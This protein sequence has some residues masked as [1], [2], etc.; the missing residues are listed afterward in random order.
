MDKKNQK[1][2]LWAIGIAIFLLVISQLPIVPWFA[3][4]TRTTCAEK[5]LSYFDMDGNVLDAQGIN[6]GNAYNVSFES[7]K[8]GQAVRF[9]GTTTSYVDF[10]LISSEN[11]TIIMWIKNYS[12]GSDWYFAS[13]TNGVSGSNE[14]IPLNSQFG[15]GLNVSVDE[16][17]VFSP[18]LTSEE[19]SNFSVGRKVCYTVS[20]EE[21]ISCQDF[22]T[23]Q[24][25]DPGYGCLNYSG[26]FFPN[27]EY[28]WLESS[29][30]KIENNLCGR[31]F[32]C[33]TPCLTT[34][35]CYTSNQ[36]CI[37]NLAYDCYLIANNVCV[38]KTDYASCVT[39]VSH[40][41]NLTACQAD[42]NVT[43]TTPADTTP[44]DGTTIDSIK[45]KLTQKVFEV[46]GFEVKLIH[47]LIL[48]ILVIA[49]LYFIG[50]KK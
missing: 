48:L 36:D 18:A 27:C 41:T 1:I 7:G 31:Y 35:N 15:L 21:N 20:Y 9:N 49:V 16:I 28:E 8:I 11:K 45:D 34:G 40:Y 26:D 38:K 23:E 25:T 4:I 13:E 32:Y 46:A 19:L 37:E 50:G 42:L 22:A 17:A 30:Y 2:I 14:I 5:T 10:P 43:T 39:N 12:A 24:V 3:I 6:N 47:L 44:T 29:Q 33:Q